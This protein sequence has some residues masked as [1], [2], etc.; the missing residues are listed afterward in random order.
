MESVVDK[1]ATAR[2]CPRPDKF[3]NTKRVDLFYGYKM[4][5]CD[6]PICSPALVQIAQMWCLERESKHFDAITESARLPCIAM[7]KR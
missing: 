3:K 6:Y 4:E 2:R 7:H 1:P 5:K